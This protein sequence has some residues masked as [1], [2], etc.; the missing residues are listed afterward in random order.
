MRSGA[1]AL[2][3]GMMGFSASAAQAQSAG[4]CADG[5][6]CAS[7]PET[8]ASAVADYG[9]EGKLELGSDG[10][11][12]VSVVAQRYDYDIFF[13]GCELGLNCNSLQFLIAF[14][15]DG[16]NTTELANAW[17]LNYRFGKMAVTQD[18]GLR[19]TYDVTTSGGLPKDNFVDVLDWWNTVSD[20]LFQF[21]TDRG[22]INEATAEGDAEVT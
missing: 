18:D 6:V 10:D 11:P 22:L 9:L 13:Y 2:A 17:N 15:D 16:T 8:V 19:L 14:E 21:F 20:A 12:Y 5:M 4:A 1:F 3:L 7:A